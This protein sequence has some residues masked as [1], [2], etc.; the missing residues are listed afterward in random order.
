MDIFIEEMV[1][2][3]KTGK[4]NLIIFG[5]LILAVVLSIILFMVVMPL[6]PMFSTAVFLLILGLVYATYVVVE[7][8]NAEYEYSLVN[9]EIDIDK[10]V[11]QKRRKRVTTINI[12]RLDFYGNISNPD[13]RK[14]LN[15][16]S[17]KKVY[18]CRDK[19]AED[20]Y[21]A[22]YR[23]GDEGKM[24]IF[25]PSEKIISVIEKYNQRQNVI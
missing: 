6:V 5:T 15:D 20:T 3:R 1:K 21:F 24:V 14:C 23:D 17:L 10:I 18:A 25:S 16:K 9:S 8:Y 22:V 4:D 2:R 11:A 13:F 19:N 7:N 12:R